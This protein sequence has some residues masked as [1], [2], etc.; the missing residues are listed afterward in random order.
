MV[1]SII[2]FLFMLC[3]LWGS[4]KA[5]SFAP[6]RYSTL[7]RECLQ[8]HK[9]QKI[10]SEAT[11]RRYLRKYSSKATIKEK[12]LVYLKAPTVE[13]SIMPPQFFSKFT[14]KEVS[15]LK[16]DELRKRIDDYI[17]YFDINKKLFLPAEK[18]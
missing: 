18:N 7:E 16:E 5:A 8:C 3:S 15:Q 13:Q 1:K 12:M 14:I 17:D 9:E 10:P 6:E 2:L 4:V 11:Y